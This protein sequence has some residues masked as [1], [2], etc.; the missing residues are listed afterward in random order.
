MR[1]F[2]HKFVTTCT[3]SQYKNPFMSPSWPC[4]SLL[5]LL[6]WALRFLLRCLRVWSI[7]NPRRRRNDIEMM[8]VSS[9]SS[10]KAP[11]KPPPPAPKGIQV[12]NPSFLI[13]I[14]S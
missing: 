7:R 6:G 12:T 10:K 13:K 3:L 5:L 4:I 1:E 2:K 14:K 9:T 8:P 11:N